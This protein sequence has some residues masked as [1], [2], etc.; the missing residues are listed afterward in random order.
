MKKIYCL[1]VTDDYS[2]FT[3][4]FFLATNDETS[5]I[6][7]SFIIGIEN[8]V[9]HKVKVIRCDNGTE[10]K[11]NEMNQFCKIKGILRQISVARTH[12]QNGVAKRRNRTLI[13]VA[14][15]MLADSKLLITF[16]AELVNTAYHLGKFDGKADEDFFIGYSLNSKAFRVYNSK[17][18]I[19]DE[20]FHIKFSESTPNVNGSGPNW[21]FDIDALTRTMNYEPIVAGLQSNGFTDPKS[22]YDDGSKPSSDDGKKVDKNPRKDSECNDQE[23]EDNVNSTNNVNTVGTNEVNVVGQKT[24]I[25]LP[26][27]PNMHALEDDSIFNFSRDDED[28]VVIG[29]LQSATQ[30]RN[31]SKN[32]EEHRFVSTIQ[33]RTN[34]KD[35][36]NCLFACFLSQEEPKKVI[37]ALKDPS[38]IEAMQEELILF[39]LKEVWTLVDLPNRKRAI[40]SKWVFRNKKDKRGIV[41]RNKARLVAQGYTQEEGIDYDE[42]FVMLQELN[43]LGYF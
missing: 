11:N 13:E 37:H 26:F 2:R 3:W 19:V 12:Q 27:D 1:V 16:W 28:D 39:K 17:T 32:L 14:R 35:L 23:K 20:N 41:I 22:S 25:E 6:L 21:L 4:V 38:W 7:K 36:Q 43:Q 24:S 30:T 10:F 31:M 15:T 34:H 9:D 18:R 42:A 8:L 5:G 40:G 29:D 33:Q